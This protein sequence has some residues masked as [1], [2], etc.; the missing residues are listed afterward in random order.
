LGANDRPIVVRGAA[1]DPLTRQIS[2]RD[3]NL[4][5]LS[6]ERSLKRRVGRAVSDLCFEN[7]VMQRDWECRG[8]LW[9]SARPQVARAVARAQEMALTGHSSI[10]AVAITVALA[11]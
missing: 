10:Q 2:Y 1:D 8:D 6:G 4:A 5:S 7:A 3:L 11:K 9:R